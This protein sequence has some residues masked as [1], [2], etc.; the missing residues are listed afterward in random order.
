M[1][2]ERLK[3][4]R[5]LKMALYIVILSGV[6]YGFY[7]LLQYLTTYFDIPAEGFAPIAYLIVFGVTLVANAAIFVPVVFHI[8]IMLR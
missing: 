3:Q 4:N 8:S 7:F 5:W 6:S 2:M 1:V